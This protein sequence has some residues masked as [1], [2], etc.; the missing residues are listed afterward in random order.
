MLHT[1]CRAAMIDT[2]VGFS[3]RITLYVSAD[4]AQDTSAI[5][6]MTL[7]N[8]RADKKCTN[9]GPGRYDRDFL[10]AATLFALQVQARIVKESFG[11]VT[12]TSSIDFD[13]ACELKWKPYRRASSLKSREDSL[14]LAFLIAC[15]AAPT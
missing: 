3:L 14:S 10:I 2:F 6:F 4:S 5:L 11:T 12:T 13:E 9:V 1:E 15:F 8:Q 7:V